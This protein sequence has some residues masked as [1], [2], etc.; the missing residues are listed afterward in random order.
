MSIEALAWCNELLDVDGDDGVDLSASA[1]NVLRILCEDAWKDRDYESYIKSETLER[2]TRLRWDAVAAALK[3]LEAIGLVFVVRRRAADGT[4]RSNT[5][6]VLMNDR[7]R[8]HASALG[9]SGE[10][11]SEKRTAEEAGCAIHSDIS[12]VDQSVKTPPATPDLPENHSGNIGVAPYISRIDSRIYPSKRAQSARER[13]V[14][15][16]S[17]KAERSSGRE[18]ERDVARIARWEVFS[19][20]WPWD[21]TEFPEHARR[22]FMQLS[23]DEQAA[24]IDGGP[25]YI[26]DCKARI[27]K[28]A[29]AKT[30]I[31]GKG[32][33]ALKARSVESAAA[34]GGG[35]FFAALGTA[36]FWRWL[37]YHA[38]ARDVPMKWRS[39]R[40][41][42]VTFEGAQEAALMPMLFERNGRKGFWR[43]SEW[44]P[45][46]AAVAAREGPEERSASP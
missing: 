14:N 3:K 18:N 31:D 19:K 9:W 17:E 2:R 30:W 43:K 35:Q 28:I 22:L 32:W 37:E 34:L 12:G 27:R 38:A 39:K 45:S 6:V 44:P 1:A 20:A 4:R 5:Y 10:A 13:E 15:G 41:G 16:F 36:Q 40:D 23:D 26:A 24:A 7:A 8:T 25:R 42:S 29:H 33:L 21:T 11:C 46:T